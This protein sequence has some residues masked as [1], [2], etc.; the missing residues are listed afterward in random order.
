MKKIISIVLIAF[1]AIGVYKIYTENF[2]PEA[3]FLSKNGSDEERIYD[4]V[5]KY[6]K[7]YNDGDFDTLVKCCTGRYKNDLKAQMGLGS[8][9]LNGV[10]SK[11]TSGFLNLGDSGFENLWTI[12]TAY[13]GIELEVQEISFI[14]EDESEVKANFIETDKNLETT[15][16]FL[17]QKE[18]EIWYVA[19]DYYQ[20]SKL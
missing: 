4:T 7:A 9:V 3:E 5:Q 11:L 1:I 8:S 18:D 19:S 6:V 12:G 14:S 13:A 20:Y 10:L 16:Y 15:V 17:M 2:A